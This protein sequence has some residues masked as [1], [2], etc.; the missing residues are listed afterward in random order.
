MKSKNCLRRI[1]ILFFKVEKYLKVDRPRRVAPGFSYIFL[2]L[3]V[4]LTYLVCNND[5]RHSENAERKGEKIIM[6]NYESFKNEVEKT[7]KDYLPEHFQEMELEVIPVNKVNGIKDGLIMTGNFQEG[8]KVSPTLYINDMYEAY[9][10]TG[11]FEKVMLTAAERMV[12]GFEHIS[13]TMKI[14]LENAKDNIVFQVVNTAWNEEMLQEIPHREFLDL[15]IIY[16][17]IISVDDE[18]VMSTIVY[19]NLA[20]ELGMKEEE[21]FGCAAKNTCRIFPP[22]IGRMD[23]F[24]K[25]GLIDSGMSREEADMLSE[26]MPENDMLYVITNTQK[27]NGACSILYEND[28]HELATKLGTDLYILPSSI[29]E[30]IALSVDSVELRDVV[31]MVETVNRTGVSADEQLSDHVYYYNKDTRIFTLANNSQYPHG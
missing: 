11:D 8:K 21:L 25:E 7:F 31:G 13:K 2:L 16:R 12:R 15:S 27:L 3:N 30:C 5:S 19:N 9:A 4:N 17:L 18:G 22:S 6:M 24:V 28:I 1:D 10:Q 14:D 20:Q 26:T 23:E 29:H